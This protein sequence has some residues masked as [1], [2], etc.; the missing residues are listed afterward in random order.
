MANTALAL[1]VDLTV[2]DGLLANVEMFDGYGHEYEL[3]AAY[4]DEAPTSFVGPLGHLSAGAGSSS[5]LSTSVQAK[6][7]SG[8]LLRADSFHLLATDM[9]RGEPETSGNA[10]ATQAAARTA[11]LDESTVG[12]WA[13]N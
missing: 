8:V 12:L 4:V 13:G 5:S 1:V 11:E 10:A 3:G 9:L 6:Q 2:D 7:P